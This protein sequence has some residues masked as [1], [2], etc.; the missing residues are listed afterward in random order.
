[1]EVTSLEQHETAKKQ[2]Q[3]NL[4]E[5]RK[6]RKRAVRQALQLGQTVPYDLGTLLDDGHSLATIRKVCRG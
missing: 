5:A 6:A 2:A 3:K 1:M 4:D